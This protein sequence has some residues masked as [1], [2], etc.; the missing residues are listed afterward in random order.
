MAIRLEREETQAICGTAAFRKAVFFP[1]G[2][3]LHPARLVQVLKHAVLDRGVR[4][5]ENTAVKRVTPGKF[6]R[7][8]MTEWRC[9][10]ARCGSGR[11][12]RA[13]RNCRDQ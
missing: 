1:E 2:A 13:G 10:G 8:E 11:E 4:I 5:V 7:V 9:R 6:S 12:H 3:N